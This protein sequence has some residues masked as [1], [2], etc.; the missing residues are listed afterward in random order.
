MIKTEFH[1]IDGGDERLYVHLENFIVSI[2]VSN[3]GEIVDIY[4]VDDN[5][6]EVDLVFTTFD[7]TGELK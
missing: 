4:T 7:F 6:N 5:G 2:S 3:E 1:S